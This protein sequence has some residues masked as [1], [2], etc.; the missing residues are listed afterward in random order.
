MSTP[1]KIHRV[2]TTDPKVYAFRLE[3]GFD[4]DDLDGVAE[5]LDAAFDA[6][7]KINMILLL[8]EMSTSDAA[9]NFS[10]ASA[11]TQARALS[12]VDRYAVVGAPDTAEKMIAAFD[13]VSSIEAKT[14]ARSDEA[15][16]WRF[17][18]AEPQSGHA[19]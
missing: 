11:R 19:V 8:D 3:R 16:A 1:P 6:E 12:H 10:L 7:G 5:T 4:G 15:A 13:S 2:P 9:G 14:F 18:G 17:V